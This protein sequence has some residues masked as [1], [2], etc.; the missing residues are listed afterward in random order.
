MN[1]PQ[2]VFK[3]VKYSGEALT[4]GFST[5]RQTSQN[6]GVILLPGRSHVMGLG[7]DSSGS[8]VDDS[9]VYTEKV[10]TITEENQFYDMKPRKKTKPTGTIDV[11]IDFV[12]N[13]PSLLQGCNEDPGG[14]EVSQYMFAPI[15]WDETEWPDKKKFPGKR[16]EINEL[17]S[18]LGYN[19]AKSIRF[20]LRT[21]KESGSSIRPLVDSNIRAPWVN[22]KWDNGLGF[23]TPAA[24]STDNDGETPLAI[25]Q[26]NTTD[27][28]NGYSFM[29]PT[30]K[31][32]SGF[33]RVILYD[34]PREDLVSLGQLQHANAGRFSYEP[35]YIVGN[36]YANI[37][38]P[39]GEWREK[40]ASDTFSK[41]DNATEQWKI[42]G[43]FS[44]YDA[45]Y[46]VN[47]VVWDSYIFTTLPQVPDNHS[48]NE[49]QENYEKLLTGEILLPNPRFIPYEPKG[50]TFEED[51]L[52]QVGSAT[53]GSFFHNAGH[54]LVDGAFNIHS[55]SVDAWE[56]F[57][58]GTRGLP[59]QKID[60]GG[61]ISGYDTGVDEVR[62]PRV[63]STFGG[64]T[65]SGENDENF[66]TGF[67]SLVKTEDQD[68][69]R[70]LA[71]AIV[72]EIKSRGP[73]RGLADFVNRRLESGE[74]GASG[75]LQAALDKSV[76]L[77]MDGGA[78]ADHSS[79]PSD[80]SQA[81]G[82]PGHLLQ[83]DILQALS[84]YMTARSDTFTIRSYG[85]A[86]DKDGKV[87]ARAWCE[88]TVQ[89][90]PDA[91]PADATAGTILEELAEPTSEFG[92]RFVIQSFRWLNAEEI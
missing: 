39:Q 40:N 86:V 28:P 34:V 7:R 53:E 72:D 65:E 67:R 16:L 55:T 60:S 45:S 83:G 63:T 30:N 31:P 89:R 71:Q 25:M 4:S 90:L 76:N 84:P 74:E 35:S 8:A 75:P 11:R 56:A 33:D 70:E 47:E 36:S 51:T 66:W 23:P 42:S 48:G 79:I 87:V 19:S 78:D 26:M 54:L 24:Y 20:G 3:S 38:I 80:Q 77:K 46:L 6:G 22:P 41:P 92:R 88:A 12:M 85:D 59:V 14:R 62:F 64:A 21:T 61:K 43:N 27:A 29:G 52:K 37:R 10:Q 58:S 57:L 81:A 50:S 17:G 32:S 69:V 82:F 15:A 91:M 5:K 44:L 49:T 9:G 73:F 2:T 18:E 1:F 68:E 13:R